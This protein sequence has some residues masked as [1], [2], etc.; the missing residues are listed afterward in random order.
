MFFAVF[1]QTV[2]PKRRIKE[3]STTSAN[4]LESCYSN[5]VVSVGND[6]NLAD[7]R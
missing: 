3:A 4:A 2:K 1:F 7:S 6:S 5:Y